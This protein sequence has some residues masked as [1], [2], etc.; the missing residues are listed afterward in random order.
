VSLAHPSG[1]TALVFVYA[2]H[3]SSWKVG[4]QE[5]LFVSSKAEYGGGKAI[6]G[7]VP[8]CWPQFADRGPFGKHGFC[9]NS[10]KWKV[11]RTS[12]EPY[13]C[14]VLGLTDDEATRA[15]FPFSFELRYSVTLDGPDSVSVSMT[16][17]NTG[18]ETLEFTTALHT[19][20]KVPSVGKVRLLGLQGLTYEDSTKKGEKAEQQEEELAI[21]G[22]VDRVYLNTPAE[23]FI[24]DQ[25]SETATRILKMGFPDAVVWNIGAARAG[26]LKD[27]GDGE[28]EDYVCYEAA[29]IAKP[30]KLAPKSSWTAG[31]TFSKLERS[32]IPSL[33]PPSK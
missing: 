22:E 33:A 5:Q 19:Y 18:E 14:V 32:K 24:V 26:G 15:A 29:A 17:I 1:A 3:L 2:A 25:D 4:G 12:T 10:D 31:Q 6:R 23:A 11:V 28:W 27:L 9:R 16:V 30:V 13:P 20:F 21:V 8:V 7:G